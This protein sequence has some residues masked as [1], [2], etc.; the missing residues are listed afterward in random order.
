MKDY[1]KYWKEDIGFNSNSIE[2]EELTKEQYLSYFYQNQEVQEYYSVANKNL[3]NAFLETLNG[4][5]IKEIF[6]E[7]E[8]FNFKNAVDFVEQNFFYNKTKID[9]RYIKQISEIL[10]ENFNMNIFSRT[11]VNALMPIWDKKTQEQIY[12]N[13]IGEYRTTGLEKM[14]ANGERLVF[15]NPN[16]IESNMNKNLERYNKVLLDPL[17]TEIK[18]VDAALL[19]H[20][21]FEFIH[22]FAEGN[23][24]TGRL[25]LDSM[26]FEQNIFPINIKNKRNHEKYLNIL[27]T[28]LSDKEK[29]KDWTLFEEMPTDFKEF[30]YELIFEESNNLSE[31]GLISKE[32]KKQF[33][34]TQNL[35]KQIYEYHQNK[36]IELEL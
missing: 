20:L 25:V 1:L 28:T 17:S 34:S 36:N 31:K 14:K 15:M 5:R 7:L 18:K 8:I 9:N 27:S 11:F 16:F 10:L 13:L 2:N 35:L 19:F 4:K 32:V 29:Q 3:N 33:F 12:P 21:N 23:G 22:P 30:F 6:T 26:F 24:R